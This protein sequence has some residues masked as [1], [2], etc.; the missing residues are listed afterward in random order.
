[1][2]QKLFLEK[3]TEVAEWHWEEH[4]GATYSHGNNRLNEGGEVPLYAHLDRI[5]PKPCPYDQKA[6]PGKYE[7]EEGCYWRC[8]IKEYLDKPI[9]IQRCS[10]CGGLM[11]PK[12]NFIPKPD[13]YRYAEIILKTDKETK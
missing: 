3:L 1:M 12:G 8:E 10:T 9:L 5:K 6:T 4:R 2:D 11:T 7:K 13:H